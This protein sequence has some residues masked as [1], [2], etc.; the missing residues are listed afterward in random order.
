M[1]NFTICLWTKDSY[2]LYTFWSSKNCLEIN[3]APCYG[4]PIMLVCLRQG[5]LLSFNAKMLKLGKS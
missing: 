1:T 4:S 3:R 2:L 5:L